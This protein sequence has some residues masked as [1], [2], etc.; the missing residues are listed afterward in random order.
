MAEETKKNVKQ[1]V[2]LAILVL[3]VVAAV[4]GY[5]VMNKKPGAHKIIANGDVAPDFTLPILTGQQMR[6]AD[7][8]GKVVMVHFWATWCPP[9][10]DEVPSLARLQQKLAGTDFVMLAVSVDDNAAVVSSFLR[11]NN[12]NLPVLMNPDKSVAS[13]YGT[14]KFPETYIL[15]RQGVVRFKAIGPRNWDDPNALLLIKEMLAS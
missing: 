14:F 10:V 11:K 8:K 5:V 15:D 4:A 2:F 12:L 13:R 7:L 1:V 9:C 6:L 3:I